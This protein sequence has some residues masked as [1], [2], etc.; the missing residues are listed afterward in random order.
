VTVRLFLAGERVG[1]QLTRA[2]N[3]NV[4]KVLAAERGAA[5]DVVDYV[6]PRARADISAAGK[7]GSRWTD[8]FQGKVTEGGGFIRI[9][10]TEK[11]PYWRVFQFGAVIHGRPLLWIPLSFAKDAQGIR[12]R[13]YPG[14]L[15]RVDRKSG[16]APLLMKVGKPAEPKYFGKAS[17]TIPKKFH[18]VEIIRD[19]ARKM[20]SFYKDHMNGK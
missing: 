14:K 15:F 3:K 4:K 10:F 18:L 12:A 1:P 11:V 13:D 5:Q 17:V 19:G 6:V 20:K 7:F 16:K 8:G 9:A 2:A